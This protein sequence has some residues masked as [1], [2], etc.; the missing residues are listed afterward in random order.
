MTAEVDLIAAETRNALLVPVEALRELSQ[1]QFAV[2]VVTPTGELEV[3]AVTV[4]L[5]DPVNVEILDGL[6]LGEVVSVGETE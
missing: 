6:E 5:T 1:G 2:S 3:R 4:G